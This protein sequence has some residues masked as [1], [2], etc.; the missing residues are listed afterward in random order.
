MLW[1]EENFQKL[2]FD[3]TK[4]PENADLDASLENILIIMLFKYLYI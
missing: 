3:D 2:S 4:I 1:L